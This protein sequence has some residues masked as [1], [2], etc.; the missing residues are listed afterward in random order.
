MAVTLGSQLG[1]YE[2]T[3]LLGKGGFGEV[4]RAKDKKLKR[5]VAIKI[6]PD[7]F[8]SNPD[9]LTRFQREAE[10]LA[11]LNHP[12]IA[13]IYDLATQ[14]QSQ[15]LVLELVGGE[16]LAE[17]IARGP[18][19]VE[20]SLNIAKQIC[21][22]LEASHEKGVI[23]RDLKPANIKITT[24]GKVKVLDFGLAKIRETSVTSNL[25]NS[26]T[27]V[28]APMSG[29]ILGTAAYMSPEQI[30]GLSVDSRTDVFALGLIL[31]EMLTGHQAFNG[32][33]LTE[34]I[35]DVLKT[36][37]DW[38][39][40]PR[41][42]PRDVRRILRLCVAKD[43]RDRRG[44]ASDVRVDIEETFRSQTDLPAPPHPKQHLLGRV[45]AAVIFVGIVVV[46]SLLSYRALE[47]NQPTPVFAYIDAPTDYVLGES[48][49]LVPLP[50][51]TPIVFTP[52]GRALLIQA[53]RAG[54]P[55]LFLRSLDNPEAKAIAGTEDARTPF[56]SPDGRWV[57]FSANGEL[58]KVP[59]EGGTPTT[60]CPLGLTLGPTG[61]SWGAGDVILYAHSNG[62]IF[63]V[64]AGGGT[65]LQVTGTPPL[66]RLY[67][68]PYFLPDGK[69]F[70]YS[71]VSTLDVSDA[72]LM[73]Q[74]LDGS[75]AKVVVPSATD[76]RLLSPGRLAFIRLGTLMTVP[77]DLT[78]GQATGDA[79]SALGSVMQSGLRARAG[80]NNTGAGMFAVSSSG[81]LAAIR[82]PVAGGEENH[83]I[84][85]TTD[86]RQ[87]PAEPTSGMP[88]GARIEAFISPDQTRAVVGIIGP[89]RSGKWLVD[90]ARNIWTA[91]GDCTFP[92]DV[93][94]SPDGQRL[95][96]A[97]GPAL[98]AH[99][100]GGSPPDQ[101]LLREPDR[102][103]APVTW[104]ADG[105][106]FYQ[107]AMTGKGM[108]IKVL[109]PGSGEGK[110]VVPMGVGVNADVS[111][112]GR[113]IAFVTN[114]SGQTYVVAQSLKN[115]DLRVQVSAAGGNSPAWSADGTTLYY[116][117]R[118]EGF[119]VFAVR[120]SST[121]ALTASSPKELFSDPTGG[122]N[123]RCY[124]ITADGSR[125][126]MRDNNND[127]RREKVTR[128]DLILNWASTLPKSK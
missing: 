42:V 106:I 41:E 15:F 2:I 24:D 112:D 87:L 8:S 109:E 128:I 40:L 14:D 104:L 69:R 5:E 80:A 28:T 35:S 56:V 78:S 74:S 124:D 29:M 107:S 118:G 75:A 11:S 71:D 68:T 84:W 101:E 70:L 59:I 13:A 114:Q 123:P 52:D 120:I 95:L 47:H 55:Q 89:T 67:A 32:K 102:N 119:R 30:R 17:R 54:K 125:F 85:V 110:V 48:D 72:K 38:N 16:T 61:A 34:T 18:I 62:R 90:W 79:V 91:C 66:T 1:S 23:H 82:G 94:W 76:G 122:C 96:G 57:G 21:E 49:F 3:A 9:R 116:Q 63:R 127:R 97:I 36:E 64:P 92:G 46:A 58:R 111:R 83:L 43:L 88:V 113:L 115:P 37:P 81:T 60:I 25:S 22:A 6:L 126:L 27:L 10:V 19:P 117:G 44:S 93:H 20:E 65:P 103:L 53:A 108:E 105:R 26:P 33:D 39:A 98:I 86:G 12:N 7:E 121:G 45:L 73:I 77:F 99:T 31:F 100:I 50:T 4:Y 51:R